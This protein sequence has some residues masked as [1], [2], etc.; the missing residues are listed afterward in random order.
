MRVLDDLGATL[1]EVVAAPDDLDLDV[2][3]IS[4]Y[5]PYDELLVGPGDLLLGV[6]VRGVEQ[7]AHLLRALG[8]AGAVGLVVKLPVVVDES[9]RAAV[10]DSGVVLLGLTRA[11]QWLQV[12]ALLRSLLATGEAGIGEPAGDLFALANAVSAL[13]DA[14]VTIE[15]RSS[16]VLAYSGRQDE[17][18]VGR[19]ETILGRQVPEKYLRV[20]E[21]RGVFRRVFG[22]TAPVYV[23]SIGDGMLPRVVVAVR[24]G[25]ELLGS[26]W[27]AVPGR[28]SPDRSRAFEDAAKVV[29]LHMLR[30]RAGSD[31]G[32]R[33]R[34]DLLA[35]VI[36]DGPGAADA[37]GRLG[38]AG[39]R[40]CVIAAQALGD[41]GAALEGARQRLTDALALH[42]AAIHPRSAT[43]M[44]GGIT[45][46]LVPLPAAASGGDE[47]A[48][49][50]AEDFL[51]RT[52][53]RDDVMIGVGRPAESLR[54][55]A[56]SRAQADRALRVLR[57]RRSGRRV[58]RHSD[59]QVE[60][61]LLR[62]S[63]VLA[64]DGEGEHGPVSALLDYDARH[65]TS[66]VD[67]LL[68]WLD[69]FGD[70]NAAAAAVHVHPNTFRYRLRRLCEISGVDLADADSRLAVLL[71]LRLHRLAGN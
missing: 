37:A 60:S 20:M 61:L 53:D 70:V 6:G 54:Q 17:A 13:L 30:Q 35:S 64:E 51:S 44:I 65:Q 18:D 27:A 10:R 11:A 46:A 9:M 59:V 63:D 26:M 19:I 8:A 24:A 41:K 57:T 39:G 25:D 67:T 7:T 28:L 32:R 33:L 66:F 40:L 71:Q 42:L 2:S 15:D 34:A 1:L 56:D 3:G 22:S 68:A 55:V 48:L 43:A 23:D 16:R 21:G 52:G 58:A 14:P 47:H 62:L 12:A 31:V 36:E 29:A 5:D 45:Y 38:I 50:V 4:L 49:R 69:T